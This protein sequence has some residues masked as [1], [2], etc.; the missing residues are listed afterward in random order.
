MKA[1]FTAI[2]LC[3]TFL[4]A[5]VGC[6]G[7]EPS[8]GGT[9]SKLS[10]NVPDTAISAVVGKFELPEYFVV[11]DEWNVYPEYV[12]GV[13][14]V[15]DSDDEVVPLEDNVFRATKE[16]VYKITYTATGTDVKKVDD[17]VLKVAF[18]IP[19]D[20]VV[21][22]LSD[23]ATGVDKFI[24]DAKG[25]FMAYKAAGTAET[26]SKEGDNGALK[27]VITSDNTDNYI[28][29]RQP[30]TT[31][32]SMFNYVKFSVYND[33][34]SK[35]QIT[36]M[37]GGHTILQ[38]NAWT[39]VCLEINGYDDTTLHTG[40]LWETDPVEGV[41]WN[42][43]RFTGSNWEDNTSINVFENMSGSFIRVRKHDSVS[44]NAD[45]KIVLFF[46]TIMA[47]MEK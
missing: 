31:D 9:L 12:V 28:R 47:S 7:K 11:D 45:N 16:G 30:E 22:P 23:N 15:V 18:F 10:I 41:V 33:S 40:G 14:K 8:D 20:A 29:F 27:L 38:P 1:F 44:L 5:C 32:I 34:D 2:I 24:T 19:E 25:T 3:V 39:D 6:G 42:P 46:S 4:F 36:F 26:Y 35:V 43:R 21:V 37:Y 17:A 13:L